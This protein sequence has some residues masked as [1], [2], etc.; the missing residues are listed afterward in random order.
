MYQISAFLYDKIAAASDQSVVVEIVLQTLET[1]AVSQEAHLLDLGMG[2]GLMAIELAERGYSVLGVEF[3]QPMLE[4]AL[5]KADILPAEVKNRL[6]FLQGDITTLTLE[7]KNKG[8]AAYCL[9]NTVNHLQGNDALYAFATQT[10]SNLKPGGVLF[11]DADTLETF[12]RFFHHPE[13]MVW[14]DGMYQLLRSS[15]FNVE[16]KTAIHT[17]VLNQM[18]RTT[19]QWQRVQEETMSLFYF[20]ETTIF[21]VFTLIGFELLSVSPFNPSPDL[22]QGFIPKGFWVFKKPDA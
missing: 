11:F 2:S 19:R 8:D 5:K 17:A 1:Q 22:Y 6:K 4:E 12:T 10:F 18:N 3:A 16:F 9:H 15:V 20:D 13:T 21:K 14:D 7:N